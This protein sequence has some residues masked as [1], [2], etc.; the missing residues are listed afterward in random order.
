MSKWASVTIVTSTEYAVEIEDSQT[1]EDAQSF[2][3]EEVPFDGVSEVKKAFI[4][5]ADNVEGL[6]NHADQVLTI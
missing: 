3:M 5:N 2:A 6:C 4:V 1:I